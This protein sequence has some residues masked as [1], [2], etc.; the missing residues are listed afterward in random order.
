LSPYQ[1]K[2]AIPQGAFSL[3]LRARSLD[4]ANGAVDVGHKPT[5]RWAK[6]DNAAQHD[7]YFGT[8][9]A[10][11]EAATTATADLYRGRQALDAASYTPKE[12]PL[13]W[14]KTYYWRVDEVNDAAAD[15]PWKGSV[16]SFTTATFLVVDDFESYNDDLEAQTTIF[17]TW[18]DGY[19]NGLSGST[20]GN[21]AAP[22][23]ERTI[24]HGGKQAMPMDY[25]NLNPPY[26]SEAQRAFA[27]AEDWT[28][29]GVNTLTL[30]FRGDT[31][32]D[33]GPLYVAIEDSTGK[34]AVVMNPDPAA[35]ATTTWT[36]WKIPLTSFTGVNP[37]QVKKIYVGVGD[38]NKPVQDGTG[39]IY[40]DDIRVIKS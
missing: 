1:P 27:P 35:V 16:W 24:V 33:A 25:S 26:F 36:E 21:I 8:D 7:V 28:V 14:G 15:S 29:N 19:T 13:E 4:P 10:A 34:L 31:A 6:G 3:P 23:A 9:P 39:R 5:L 17:D 20:V 37:A 40:I 18:I 22:F 32:N 30:W 38:R 12:V 11:V 2:Q